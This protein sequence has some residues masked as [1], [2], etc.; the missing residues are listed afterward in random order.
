[1]RLIGGKPHAMLQ[2]PLA[3]LISRSMVKTNT[4]RSTNGSERR[5]GEGERKAHTHFYFFGIEVIAKR[6]PSLFWAVKVKYIASRLSN[7]L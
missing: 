5:E 4:A 6:S 1:M 7:V 3:L 2:T